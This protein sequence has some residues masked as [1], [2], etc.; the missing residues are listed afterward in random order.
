MYKSF[1]MESRI[2]NELRHKHVSKTIEF[3][4]NGSIVKPS[5][6][7]INDVTFLVL[8]YIEG[9]ELMEFVKK[10]KKLSEK[11]GKVLFD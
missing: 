2:L 8:E 1:E 7:I 5:G 4:Q 11:A 3:G 6:N 9:Q 10:S